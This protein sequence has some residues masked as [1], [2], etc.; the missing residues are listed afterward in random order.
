MRYLA[1]PLAG[2]LLLCA[3][4]SNENNKAEA[5]DISIENNTITVSATSPVLEKIKTQTVEI[6]P[7]KAKFSTSGIV[8]A[9]PTSYAQIATPFAGRIVRSFVRLGQNVTVG[10]PLFEISSPSFFETS[11]A[12]FGAKQEM[13]QA[14][15]NLNRE[16]DLLANR[17]GVA[18]DVEEAEVTYQLKKQDFENASSALKVF[19]V[20]PS[21]LVLG[22]PLI[23]RSPLQG[24]VVANH[25]IIGQYIKEDAEPQA[26]V[27]DLQ[28]VWVV[29]HVKERDIRLMERLQEMEI[30]L[31]AW[32]EDSIVGTIY[33]ISD[34]LDES[35]RA[36]EVII[37]CDN[38]KGQMKPFMYATVMLTDA[39]T[40]AIL[41]PNSAILQ[42]EEH[43][44]VLVENGER[45]FTK[46]PITV[47]STV[48]NKSV[49]QSGLS[50]GDRIVIEGA[51]YLLD[52]K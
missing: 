7:F 12:Y 26:V 46:T 33:H 37:E 13:Q 3:C 27:A 6:A 17:V 20:D 45:K 48:D 21:Q 30:R 43:C 16:K 8:Q 23:V 39:K 11:K 50:A 52:A 47:A 5:T 14:M 44:Y 9:I 18:K 40:D 51:F 29:A 24:K 15:K 2:A 41:I 49:I 42:H 22:E 36:A 4:A 35:T 10:S 38:H 1:I 28:K 19:Q 25:I 32:P 34:L 31:A